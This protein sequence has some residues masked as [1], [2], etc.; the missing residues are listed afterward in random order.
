M[1]NLLIILTIIL[2]VF[3][4]GIFAWSHTRGHVIGR[5]PITK[6]TAWIAKAEHPRHFWGYTLLHILLYLILAWVILGLW[7]APAF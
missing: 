7:N 5:H 2:L 6:N 1:K 3:G 4:V